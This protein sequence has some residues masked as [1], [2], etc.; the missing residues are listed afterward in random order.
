MQQGQ[1]R[2]PSGAA[3]GWNSLSRTG[4]ECSRT[5]PLG[6]EIN[7]TQLLLESKDFLEAGQSHTSTVA[8]QGLLQHWGSQER[9]GHQRPWGPDL[10]SPHSPPASGS[11]FLRGSSCTVPKA[12]C[13]REGRASWLLSGTVGAPP[14]TQDLH[15]DVAWLLDELLHKQCPIPKGGQGLRVGP[16]VVFLQLLG[17]GGG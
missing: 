7:W 4:A 8:Y 11:V 9:T 3:A 1:S 6:G 16:G 2:P 14:L 12:S 5:G 17:V 13:S 15:L 10:P